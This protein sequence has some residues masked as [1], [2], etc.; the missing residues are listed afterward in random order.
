MRDYLLQRTRRAMFGEPSLAHPPE[1]G[2]VH[3]SWYSH[4]G[5]HD[6][7]DQRREDADDEQHIV[8]PRTELLGG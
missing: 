4:S 6:G 1:V 8:L 2:V 5:N 3:A 7:R